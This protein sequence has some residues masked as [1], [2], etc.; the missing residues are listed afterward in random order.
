MNRLLSQ[1][2]RTVT[3]LAA[4]AL[5]SGC[6]VVGV[7]VTEPST[8]A[9]RKEAR[10]L[11]QQDPG[12]AASGLLLKARQPRVADTERLAALL[13][14]VR[15]TSGA[16]VGTP[17]HAINQAATRDIVD[18]A[19]A[20]DFKP[21]PLAGGRDVLRIR[22]P[23]KPVLDPR[24]ATRLVPAADIRIRGLRVRTLQQGAGVPYVAWFAPD[25]PDLSGQP[26][27]PPRAGLSDPVTALV[28]FPGGKPELAFHRTLRTA[29]ARIDGR[30]V[31][32]AT[33]FSAPLAYLLSQGRNRSLDLKAL[34]FADRNIEHARLH[35]FEIYD[36][37]KIPVVFVHGLMS[38]PETWTP[39]VN[40]LLADP[41]IRER[42]QFW[43][44]LYP[45][46]LPVWSSAAKLRGELDR[47]RETLDPAGRNPNLD[48]IVLVGHSMGGLISSL[49]VRQGGE[50]LWRQ[51]T[52]TPPE[53]MDLSPEAKQRIIELVNFQP[54][55]DVSR[56][57]FFATP[58]RG[59]RLAV[60][61]V[62][63]FF[64]RLVRIPATMLQ[65]ERVSFVSA[66]REEFR[67]L[68]IAP[69]NSL[70]FLRADSPLL[71]AI[72]NLPRRQAIP[73]H[74]IIGDRG[75]GDTP[76]SSD[77]VVPY[78]SAHLPEAVSEKIV[79][80]AHDANSNPEGIRELRRI[81]LLPP[82]RDAN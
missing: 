69:A 23:S 28:T 79:P 80:S 58:H 39:A 81:L 49:L 21:L 48:R 10:H 25:S 35:Q 64:S 44:F 14:A 57:V 32:L 67:D 61:P 5:A 24:S 41:A 40:E 54:R 20:A 12:N 42:Y 7:R 19:V 70:V 27:V 34:V 59:S 52:D 26:G 75:R 74:S 62:V 71:K 3:L 78:W 53:Q 46:G 29:T 72:L 37:S 77:G 47:F 51:F 68:F 17:A 33:D 18:V 31:P 9:A 56:T 66:I 22:P 4:V 2:A 45:T 1:A 16:R 73:L 15:L 30:S 11:A 43:F 13:E 6:A 60:N 65:T 76:D 8:A 38:R 55:R 50:K 36:P 63:S 82:G